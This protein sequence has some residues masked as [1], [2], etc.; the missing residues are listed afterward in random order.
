MGGAMFPPCY[1]TWSQTMV[2]LM[3]TSFKRSYACTA[4]LSVPNPTAGHHQPMP[5][6]ESPGHTQESLGQSLM[7]SL[8]LFPGSWCAQGSVCAFQESVSPVLRKF[9]WFHG[10]I[11]GNLLQEV[12]CHTQVCCTQSPCPWGSPLLIR[13]ST[14]DKHSSVS[15]TVL[16]GG[17]S[18]LSCDSHLKLFYGSLAWYVVGEG[19]TQITRVIPEMSAASL[20]RVSYTEW[21][22]VACLS[23]LGNDNF[24]NISIFG[25]I[26]VLH[27][28]GNGNPL[29]Y[30]RLENPM[31]RGGWRATVH[32][33]TESD[34]T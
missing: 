31:N 24:K 17:N 30:H 18:S 5:L 13:T 4:T 21:I 22:S 14:G 15:N 1:L 16:A 6:P 3:G 28:E 11:N 32:G 19:I 2:K 25:G 34:T 10:G 20:F 29:Q 27:G 12:L 33:V 8:F 26:V 9:W 23:Y 7:G